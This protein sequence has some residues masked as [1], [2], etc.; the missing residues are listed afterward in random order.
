[1]RVPSLVLL[2]AVTLSVG[3]APVPPPKEKKP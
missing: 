3:F 1:M 2:A